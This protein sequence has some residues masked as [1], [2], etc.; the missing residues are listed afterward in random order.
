MT[1]PRDQSAARLL[2]DA[3][4]IPIERCV[5]DHLGRAWRVTAVED[6]DDEASHPAAILSDGAYAV[7]VKLGEGPIA[8][9]QFEREI[10][11][12]RLL[13]ARGG[14]LTPHVIGNL[15]V[16]GGV[17]MVMEAVQT[18]ERGRR[19]WRQIGRALARVHGAKSERF[20]LDAPCYWGD[21]Y[22]DN[23][24]LATWS[25]FFWQ[26]RVASRLKGAVDAGHLSLALAAEV[27]KLATRLPALC[28]PAVEPALLHGDAQQNNFISTAAG[29]VMIDPCVHYGHPEFDLAY[30]DFFAPVPD[31]LFEGYREVA[32]L[33]LAAF[34]R[35]RDL[36][37]LPGWLAMI[38]VVGPQYVDELRAVLT[39]YQRG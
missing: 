13:T 23:R 11:G 37:R 19:R 6:K 30:V 12:L 20:G 29:P 33:D 7:F 14:A 28:G 26:R 2:Q 27:E 34:S 21:L 9:K 39:R 32:P 22:R 35:R 5:S 1:S 36:W 3:L 31:E 24:P 4:R 10:A 16:D 38:Q 17:V 18:I 25:D 8:A 15:H